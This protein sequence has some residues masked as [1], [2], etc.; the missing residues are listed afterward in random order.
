MGAKRMGFFSR[1]E[2]GAGLA[3]LGGASTLAAVKK[4]LPGVEREV[5]ASADAALRFYG[6]AFD[7]LLL[8]PNQKIVDVEAAAQ[9]RAAARSRRRCCSSK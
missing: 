4:A 2:F 5:A 1:S 3:A 9:A 8:E 7:F 6:F